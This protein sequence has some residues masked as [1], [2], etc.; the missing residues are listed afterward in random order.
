MKSKKLLFILLLLPAVI[1]Y[2][3]SYYSSYG[4]GMPQYFVSSQ[5]VGMGGAGIA[6]KQ[7]LSINGLNPAALNLNGFTKIAVNFKGEMVDN[8]VGDEHIKTR[9]GNASGF[10]FAI[11]IRQNSIAFLATLRPLVE[12][13]LAVDFSSQ[14]DS[15]GF[16]RKVRTSGG[17]SAASVGLQVAIFD[18]LSLGA[19]FDFNFGAYNETWK[20]EFDDKLYLSSTDDISSHLWGTGIHL[21]AVYSPSSFFSIGATFQSQSDLTIETTTVPGSGIKSSPVIQNATYPMAVGIGTAFNLKKFLLAFDYYN[22]F[23]DEYNLDGYKNKNMSQFKRISGGIEYLDSKDFLSNYPR[24]IAL[25]IGGFYSQLPFKDANG[26]Y[27]NELFGTL[28]FGFPFNR[29]AGRIDISFELGKRESSDSDIYSEKVYRISASVT[30][31]E[32]WFQRLF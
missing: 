3:D 13:R 17:I 22:Q 23:W 21:G 14:V 7:Y 16:S 6:V 28:G 30:S 29:N 19:L 9:Q 5:A 25:R 31:A 11:P 10:R 27:I 15:V 12:S 4:L 32:K 1:T 8:S 20:T 26:E 24:R 18:G 2:A